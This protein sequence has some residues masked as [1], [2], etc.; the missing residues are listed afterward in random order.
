MRRGCFSETV[1]A[2]LFLRCVDSVGLANFNSQVSKIAKSRF[3][4]PTHPTSRRPNLLSRQTPGYL[5]GRPIFS[6]HI[7][8]GPAHRPKMLKLSLVHV[9]R[10]RV[11]YQPNLPKSSTLNPKNLSAEHRKL[12]GA[13]KSAFTMA[14]RQCGKSDRSSCS[15]L[16]FEHPLAKTTGRKILLSSPRAQNPQAF[17]PPI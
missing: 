16:G 4:G 14:P 2:F 17:P 5:P 6:S 3:K 7:L 8:T 9:S 11:S 10:V 12:C 13:S 15:I 1:S